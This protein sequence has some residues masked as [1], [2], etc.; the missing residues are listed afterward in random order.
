MDLAV[1]R[2]QGGLKRSPVCH[3][4]DE[5]AA[6]PERDARLGEAH[7]RYYGRASGAP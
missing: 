7:A 4:Q 2:G 5:G 6:A 1:G 3:H